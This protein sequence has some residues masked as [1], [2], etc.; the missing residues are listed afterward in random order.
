MIKL[1][2]KQPKKKNK[3]REREKIY[4][5][6]DGVAVVFESNRLSNLGKKRSVRSIRKKQEEQPK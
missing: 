5:D 6:L 2:S 3:Q 4:L 1:L